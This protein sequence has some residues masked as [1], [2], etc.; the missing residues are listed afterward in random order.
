LLEKQIVR[1]CHRLDGGLWVRPGLGLRNQ[2]LTEA[3]RL[4]L[5]AIATTLD[6]LVWALSLVRAIAIMIAISVTITFPRSF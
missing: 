4:R 1:I 6:R 2:T 5:G 3:P